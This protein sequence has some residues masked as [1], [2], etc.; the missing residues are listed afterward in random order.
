[1]VGVNESIFFVIVFIL[2]LS[3]PLVFAANDVFGIQ[4]LM[5][6]KQPPLEWNS[7]HWSTGGL[8]TVTGWDPSDPTGWSRR[9]GDTNLFEKNR[10][11]YL[12]VVFL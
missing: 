12:R 8:R 3:S 7:L 6:S 4:M 1:M 2:C 5:P 10:V 9:R 11:L